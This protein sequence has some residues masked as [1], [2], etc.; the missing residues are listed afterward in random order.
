MF[1]GLGISVA[2][3]I[4]VVN[5]EQLSVLFSGAD[6]EVLGIDVVVYEV[7]EVIILEHGNCLTAKHEYR[8]EGEFRIRFFEQSCK[9]ASKLFQHNEIVILLLPTPMHVWN[10][11]PTL[12]CL[13][14]F[15]FLQDR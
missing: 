5:E 14:Y 10:T 13:K 8:F 6:H 9:I 12:H 2:Y 4:A 7:L 1:Q 3:R 15:A 11:D